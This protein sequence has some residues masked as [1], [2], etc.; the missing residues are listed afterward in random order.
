LWGR[1]GFDGNFQENLE[2]LEGVEALL[3]FVTDMGEELLLLLLFCCGG[4]GA[5]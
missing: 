1:C 3:E 5:R 2:V 4:G